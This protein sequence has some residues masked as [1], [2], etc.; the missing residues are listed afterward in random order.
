VFQ[1][2]DLATR[3]S[4]WPKLVRITAYLIKFVNICRNRKA[5]SGY[6]ISPGAALS[7]NEYSVAKLFWLKQLQAE[8]FPTKLQALQCDKSIPARSSLAP[9]TPFLDREG[10][11]RVGGRLHHSHLPFSS[12]HP[13][14]LSP[15][16]LVRLIIHHMHLRTLHGGTQLTLSALRQEYWILR[17]QS[18][19][20]S[21]IHGCV[22]C[23]RERASV[24]TQLMG[25]LPAVRV[26]KSERAFSHCGID[27]A[28]PIRIRASAGRG[29]TARK[30]Y[31]ALFICLSTRAIH[32]EL[33]GDYFFPAFL[34]A[35]SRFCSR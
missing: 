11:I 5:P 26:S 28:G 2:W 31:I 21:T 4:S 22:R 1:P 7:S 25:D 23:I 32:L 8:L 18:L 16:H 24:P 3:Y 19:V 12:R 27:Y 13:I 9:L 17:A 20:K 15:H 29:I 6:L 14:L 33:V 35:F 30:A 10:V 34:S